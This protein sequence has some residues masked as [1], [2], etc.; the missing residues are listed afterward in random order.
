[1]CWL[2]QNVSLFACGTFAAEVEAF[3]QNTSNKSAPLD[4]LVVKKTW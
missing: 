3:S 1:M 4:A 2:S